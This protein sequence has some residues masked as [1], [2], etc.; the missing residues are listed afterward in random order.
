M[1]MNEWEVT[2]SF[3][4]APALLYALQGTEVGGLCQVELPER[5]RT[6]LGRLSPLPQPFCLALA[7]QVQGVGGVMQGKWGGR[8]HVPRTRSPGKSSGNSPKFE[9]GGQ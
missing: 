8:R 6:S 4:D 7:P 3:T 5:G 1:H 2:D 9:G